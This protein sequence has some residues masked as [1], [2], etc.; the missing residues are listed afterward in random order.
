MIYFAIT[1]ETALWVLGKAT[2]IDSLHDLIVKHGAGTSIDPSY[3]FVEGPFRLALSADSKV[4]GF[5]NIDYLSG[6]GDEAWGIIKIAGPGGIRMNQ[7]ISREVFE[8]CL[9][10]IGQRL[11]GLTI[12][13]TMFPR[14][15]A[16]GAHTCLAG[17][18]SEARQLSIGYFE[19]QFG[20]EEL[21]QSSIICLGPEENFRV[22]R[23]LTCENS[24][25]LPALIKVANRLLDAGNR[26]VAPHEYL[27]EIRRH[28][29][30]FTRS[31][32]IPPAGIEF[33]FEQ[34]KINGADKFK[35]IGMNYAAWLRPDSTLTPVQRRILESDSIE[36]HPIRILGPGG[37]GK[38]LLMQL[39]A[40]R[41]QV[42]ACKRREPV[43]ILYIVHNQTMSKMVCQRFDVLKANM[44][45]LNY[46]DALLEVKTL[47]QIAREFLELEDAYVID[48]DAHEA[49]QFQ[50][51]EIKK[52]LNEEIKEHPEIVKK[53]KILIAANESE[54]IFSLL[55]LLIMSEISIAIK[56]HGLSKDKKKYVQSGKNLSRFHGILTQKERE[57]IF[58]VFE[59]YH[60]NVFET[61]EVLDADD[62]ALSLLGRLRSPIW[63]LRRRQMGYDYLFVDETQ[64]FNENERRILPF[65]TNGLRG[66]IPIVLAL[67]EAQAFYGQAAAGF[68]ALGI[69]GLTNESLGSIH[70]S[71]NAIV[72][73]A[74]FIIQR[75]TDLFGP[76]FPKFDE[77][78]QSLIP[79]SHPLASPP[80]LELLSDAK[81]TLGKFVLKRVREL[82]KNNIRQICVVIHSDQ[83]WDDVYHELSASDLPFQTLLT[84]GEKIPAEQPVVL[85][86]KPSFIGGQEFGAV[87]LVGL[88][89]G[90]V[91]PRISESDALSSA[92]E[93]Q[94]LREIY[95]S[96]T[97]A[98]YR[99]LAVVSYG[100]SP[101][102]ILADAARH[103]LIKA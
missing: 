20:S 63:D 46:C 85:M 35:S 68:A 73:L 24:K 18:G 17:R 5:W 80:R 70:R 48:V 40:M 78:A 10:V 11:Q 64:L 92:L 27:L 59:K 19:Q 25:D 99:L 101:S 31:E 103:G 34:A 57:F 62:L 90:V 84:R 3:E 58:N 95:L 13:G 15:Y 29:L 66:Y 28:L 37:S 76:D 88:E 91:P 53:S 50:V 9:Y 89:Q 7:S 1:R 86:S 98:K 42:L 54:E 65:L 26:R 61:F 67:D 36:R 52:A 8:R 47:S 82:R 94:S 69:E 23:S 33:S 21:V 60:R 30:P 96:V 6:S 22:L 74:F 102:G 2:L 38:T 87:V 72:D 93:Q 12:D 44:P 77:I 51:E 45:D 32:D 49:K 97:R 4:A 39:L 100:A 41:R 55:S 83:Y 56:G 75:S 81:Q 16:S 71:T 79:D 14:A 43:K